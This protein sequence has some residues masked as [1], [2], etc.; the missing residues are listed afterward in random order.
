VLALLWLALAVAICLAAL[1]LPALRARGAPAAAMPRAGTSPIPLALVYDWNAPN[2]NAWK[3]FL[4]ANGFQVDLVQRAALTS[5]VWTPYAAILIEQDS[6]SDGWADAAQ[7]AAMNGSGKPI[8][9]LSTGGLKLFDRLGLAI[10]WGHSRG[11]SA[12]RIRAVD[13]TLPVFHTP[14]EITLPPDGILT[15]CASAPGYMR[16]AQILAPIADVLPV[17]VAESYA[18][19]YPVVRQTERFLYWGSGE[20]P[21][22]MSEVGRQLLVNVVHFLISGWTPTPTPTRTATR[23]RTPTATRTVFL[24]LMR[25][26]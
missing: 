14:N 15:L 9:G 3:A 12:C 10:N 22:E 26:P 25:R 19:N 13:P 1:A 21:D 20:A 6:G 16:A 2:A 7:V 18:G 4:D 8:L 24:P 23:T 11:I 5:T 17:A